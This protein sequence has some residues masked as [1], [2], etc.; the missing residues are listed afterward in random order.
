MDQRNI[1]SSA[2]DDMKTK[3]NPRL[4]TRA[5]QYSNQVSTS[6]YSAFTPSKQ[7]QFNWD[8]Q[9]YAADLK[10]HWIACRGHHFGYDTEVI[11]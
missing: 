2:G 3:Q 8:R 7:A 10:Q 11:E 6:E 5:V 1:G 4:Q 9:T